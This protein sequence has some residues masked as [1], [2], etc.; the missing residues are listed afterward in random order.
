MQSN[1]VVKFKNGDMSLFSYHNNSI[2]RKYY[3]NGRQSRSEVVVSDVRE[4][5]TVTLSENDD[6]FIF[7]Q[8]LNYNII[9]SNNNSIQVLLENTS[10]EKN[11]VYFHAI[12]NQGVI[13]FIYNTP[14]DSNNTAYLYTQSIKDNIWK[15]AEIVDNFSPLKNSYVDTIMHNNNLMIFY[16]NISNTNNACYVAVS[17]KGVSKSVSYHKTNYDI[18]DVSNIVVNN[19]IFLSYIVKSS[20]SYQLFLRKASGNSISDPVVVTE[21]QNLDNVLIFY[22]DK[23]YIFFTSRESLYAIESDDFGNSFSKPKKIN[24]YG[25]YY[26]KAKFISHCQTNMCAND[27]YVSKGEPKQIKVMPDI[28]ADFFSDYKRQVEKPSL[29]VAKPNV[30]SN[31]QPKRVHYE[32]LADL[33]DEDFYKILYEKK[34]E[35]DLLKKQHK[36]N[37]FELNDEDELAKL[38][39]E[40]ENLKKALKKYLGSM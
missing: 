32:N 4:N 24:E 36:N 19:D 23:L 22:S 29:S 13:T 27:I 21:G 6:V 30:E 17:D 1:Y 20:F 33:S 10:N 28:Y 35:K 15:K 31:T 34:Q 25:N 40:N 12:V 9:L 14:K 37:D 39:R 38:K 16:K 3:E 18:V 8:D 26:A 11:I 2:V 7:C 5:F